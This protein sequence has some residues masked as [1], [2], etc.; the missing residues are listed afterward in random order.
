MLHS[1]DHS[2]TSGYFTTLQV[3]QYCKELCLIMNDVKF[4]LKSW[5]SNCPELHAISLKDKTADC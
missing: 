5:V 1:D 3:V 2:C 4:N